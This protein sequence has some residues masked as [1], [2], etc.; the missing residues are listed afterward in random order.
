MVRPVVPYEDAFAALS[1][2]VPLRIVVRTLRRI[3][4]QD[5]FAES[6]KWL[7]EGSAA[8]SLP[9]SEPIN[10]SH[11]RVEEKGGVLHHP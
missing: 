3:F 11:E 4:V 6:H 8:Y 5:T 7:P 9:S 10:S 1:P 2:H